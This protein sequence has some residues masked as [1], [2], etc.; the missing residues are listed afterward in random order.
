MRINLLRDPKRRFP[1]FVVR[2]DVPDYRRI[3]S[4]AVN[5]QPV[6]SSFCGILSVSE[7]ARNHDVRIGRADEKTEFLEGG[8]FRAQL[9]NRIA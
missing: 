4:I 1:H 8:D 3:N 5:Y 7:R 9:C 6:V 2:P